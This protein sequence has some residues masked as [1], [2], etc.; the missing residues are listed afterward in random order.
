MRHSGKHWKRHGF[1]GWERKLKMSR[2]S[3][4][5]RRPKHNIPVNIIEYEDRIDVCVHALTYDP[6][7]IDV[8]VTD[9]V[10]YISGT[11]TP[12]VD[13]P[14]FLVQEYPIKSF[15]RSFELGNHLNLDNIQARMKEGVLVVSVAKDEKAKGP[16]KT[17]KIE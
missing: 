5:Y 6:D 3:W 2:G 11:R 14:N 12:E 16:E 10:L 8:T 13:K 1:E 15:E 9:G 7:D 17:I 4:G